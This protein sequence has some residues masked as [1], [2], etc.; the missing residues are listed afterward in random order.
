[1]AKKL[2]MYK[3]LAFHEK[4]GTCY[5]SARTPEEEL[6][7]YLFLFN[8]MDSMNYYDYEDAL[9]VDEQVWHAEAKAGDGKSAKCLIGC[10]SGYEY[11]EVRVEWVTVPE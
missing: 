11:E 9:N 5:V 4:H 2:K 8:L 1:M 10:R 7:A 3:V 6:K